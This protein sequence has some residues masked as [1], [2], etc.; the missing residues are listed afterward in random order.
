MPKWEVDFLPRN[1][2]PPPAD[3][4]HVTRHPVLLLLVVVLPKAT[5]RAATFQ[6]HLSPA[7]RGSLL[8]QLE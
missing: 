1:S 8:A 5:F 7:L 3:P 4:G 2:D 6:R